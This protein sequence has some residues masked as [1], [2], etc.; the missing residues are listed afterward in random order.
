MS[1]FPW[2]DIPAGRD[3]IPVSEDPCTPHR[4]MW[5]LQ[6]KRYYTLLYLVNSEETIDVTL[7]LP[8]LQSIDIYITPSS[9]CYLAISLLDSSFADIFL[10]LCNDLIESTRQKATRE[11]GLVNLVNRCWRWQSLLYRKGSPLLTLQEQQGL[12]SELSFLVDHLSPSLGIARSL[13]MWQGPYGSYH[14]FVS[15][16]IDIEIKSFRTAGVPR[17]RVSSEHQLEQPSH[18]DLYLVCYA[19][20]NDQSAGYSVSSIAE[21]I[22]TLIA[23]SAPSV[24]GLFQSLLDEAG[25]AWNHD[26]ENSRWSIQS[27]SCYEVREGFPSI[28]RSSILPAVMHVEYDLNPLL[29]GE[30]SSP[31]A[32]ILA[33]LM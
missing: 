6:N 30:F 32:S 12:F 17:I 18:K 10:D 29:L 15:G 22:S 8:R 13:E 21:K 9:P 23:E 3:A 5:A 2:S 14:D 31:V 16:S 4:F 25:F 26:Y 24:S 28:I 19:L 11:E 7:E 20:S 33:S 1:T 27:L